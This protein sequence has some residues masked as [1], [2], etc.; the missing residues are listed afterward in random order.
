MNY[1]YPIF[2]KLEGRDVLVVGG[3]RVASRRIE[4]LIETG[5]RVRVVSPEASSSVEESSRAGRLEWI[6]RRFEPRDVTPQTT[7]VLVASGDESVVDAARRAAAATGALFNAAEDESLCDFH[8]PAVARER[9]VQI[10]ISAGG[11]NPSLAR[12]IRRELDA[13]LR[14]NAPEFRSCRRAERPESAQPGWV[15]LVGAGPGSAELVTVRARDLLRSADIVFHDRLVSREILDLVPADTKLVYVGKEV[16][17]AHRENIDRLLAEAAGAGRAV[18]RLKGGDPMVFGRGGEEMLHLRRAGIPYEIVPGVSSISAVPA[19]AHIP[20][21]FRGV[22][23]E[24][25]VRSGHRLRDEAPADTNDTVERTYVYFMAVSRL[26]RVVA[27]LRREGVAGSTPSAIIEH[28]TLGER[29]RQVAADLVDLP[30]AARREQIGAP[31]LVVVGDVVLFRELRLF[32]G[33]LRTV[34]EVPVT[35]SSAKS[36]S[37]QARTP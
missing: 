31:A 32:E 11:R 21:T 9:E 4:R 2:L 8:V 7:L 13:W 33:D 36:R 10:A 22:A 17:D 14:S 24:L 23:S 16:G 20:V 29:Q 28:G 25:V 26:D 6:R 27:E 19:A 34:A 15:Y 18:V 3:G 12:N 30:A 1:L 37:P 35:T 5:A